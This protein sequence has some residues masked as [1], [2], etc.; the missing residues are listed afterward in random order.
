MTYHCVEALGL[1]RARRGSPGAGASC[2]ALVKRHPGLRRRRRSA[3]SGSRAT[4]WFLLALAARRR[5]PPA[6][7]AARAAVGARRR[8]RRTA[9][10]PRGRAAR[11]RRAAR[12]GGR[13]TPSR[14]P[15]SRSAACGT[16][17]CS[18]E[19]SRCCTPTYWPEV[20]RGGE[21]LA[22][23]LG[24]R[25]RRARPPRPAR[26]EPPRPA[27]R[28]RARTGSR[29]CAHRR[30]P[31]GRLRRRGFE[32]HLT[33]VPA[34]LRAPAAR[35]RRRSP[36]RCT[37]PTRA[38]AI[39][40][41]RPDGVHVPRRPAP[42]GPGEPRGCASSSSGAAIAARDATVALSE[43]A[44]RGVPRAGSASTP[45][46]IHPGV[47]LDAFTPGG[48][49]AEAF[50]VLCPAALDAPHKRAGP[51][52][53]RRSRSSARERPGARLV[54]QRGGPLDA[55]AGRRAP[56]PRRPRDARS[57][58]TARRTSPRWRRE[59]EAFGL[60]LAESL[61]CGT[62]AVASRRR[63]GPGGHRRRRRDVLRRRPAR[64]SPAR[65]STPRG[66]RRRRRAAARP[67]ASGLD[68]CVGRA[69]GA[70]TRAL[71]N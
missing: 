34:H 48:E 58:P 66:V 64:R 23:D 70:A 19:A 14:S 27:R 71:L 59:G 65:S 5:A 54:V 44:A 47:D 17:R 42:R 1:R 10:G 13:S 7:R 38:A 41:G 49:R 55:R 25:A 57:P 45:R 20:R 53:S 46:V 9:P 61:A 63:R 2:P 26:H 68:R 40:A 6:A 21:R 69:R 8:C 22:H 43:A 3:S 56:R 30:P 12:P 60:V 24:A 51:A 16:G 28:A 29:S 31:D 67:S 4:R 50:T 32:D 37:T 33:H 35:R 15:R 52:R 39:R 18:C 62:P 36:T 11:G